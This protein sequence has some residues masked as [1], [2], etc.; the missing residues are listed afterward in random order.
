M[1]QSQAVLEGRERPGGPALAMVDVADIPLG[2]LALDAL[3][4]EAP[5]EVLASGTIQCGRYLILFAGAVE[6]VELSLERAFGAVGDA[7]YDQVLLPHAEPR[8]LP[9]IRQAA[10][11]WPDAGD[12][13]G[14]VQAGAPP[15]LA[16]A[17][18]AGL[19]GADVELVQLRIADGLGGKGIA[20]L[21][22]E[23]HDVEAAIAHAEAGFARGRNNGCSTAIIRNAEA[24]VAQA[25]LPR[26]GFFEEWRG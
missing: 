12:S 5:V 15:T 14:V 24:A 8:I 2:L 3:V 7:L 16:R 23:T 21:W 1:E 20:M 10:I 25:L 19:K 6:P 26:S 22:G 18:D 13:L 9:A 4:K 17:V 11:R